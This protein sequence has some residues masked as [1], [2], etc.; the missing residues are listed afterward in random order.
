MATKPFRVAL[1]ADFWGSDGEPRYR[2]IGL[3]VFAGHSAIHCQPFSQHLAEIDA[4]Q[5][6]GFQG[7][8]VL[9][10]RVSARSVARSHDLLFVSRFGVGYDSVDVPACTAADVVVLIAAGAVDRPVAEATITWMLALTHEVRAKDRL[11]REGRWEERTRFMGRELRDRVLGVIGLG[12]IGRALVNLLAGFGMKPPLAYDPF[13]TPEVAKRIGVRL[14]DLD[15]LM[16]TADFVSIHCP[17]TDRT[18]NLIG[19]R[20]IGLMKEDSYLI[21]T[22]RGG[23]VD[24]DALAQALKERRIAGPPSIASFESRSPRHTPWASSIPCCSPPI[25][26]RGPTSC[27][28]TSALPHA[29]GSSI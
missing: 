3:S 26:L 17:L 10:P 23:I 25:A 2:D 14:V 6:D 27:S 4:G 12:G 5:L 19:A 7:V 28:V 9:T 1:T 29:R 13:V 16:M 8:V 18:R 11:L 15:E 24:E 20:E 22:A 21:N